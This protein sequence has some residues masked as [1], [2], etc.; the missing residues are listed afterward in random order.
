MKA[1]RFSSFGEVSV[2]HVEELPT[3][4]PSPDEVLVQVHAASINPSDAKN[5]QGKMKPISLPRTPGQDFAGIIV[6]GKKGRIGQEVW[7]TGGDVGFTRD[8][9]HAEFIVVPERGA[10]LKPKSLSMIEAASV[11]RNYVTAFFGLIRKAE[12]K[13]GETVLVTG[14]SGGVGSSVIKIAKSKNARVI[15][16]YRRIPDPE[17]ASRLGIDLALSTESDNIANRVKQFTQGRGVDVAFDCVGGGLFEVA[18]NTLGSGG[19]QVNI[20]A[21]GERR[22]SFD[23]LD[24]YRRQITLFGVN[25]ITLDIVAS[26]DI[27][28][29]L[30]DAFEKGRLTPPEIVKTCSLENAVEAYRQVD[31][32]AA[33]GKIVFT[34]PH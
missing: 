33:G 11:G 5:V 32:G 9:S 26:G 17:R 28:D 18:L 34:F 19:R 24:F 7:G 14:A 8:G 20:T 29:D 1:L 16:L 6:S 12:L 31:S 22:V 25:T 27:L 4:V 2:L 23:L 15:A 10:R 21:V 30:R 3:P 13:G